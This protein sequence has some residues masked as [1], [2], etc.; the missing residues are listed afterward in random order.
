MLVG[1]RLDDHNTYGSITNIRASLRWQ[2]TD[3]H[4]VRLNFGEA[5]REPTIFELNDSDGLAPIE[6]ETTELTFSYVVPS[7]LVGSLVFWNND[8]TGD[9][10]STSSGSF[11]NATDVTRKRG[12]EWRNTWEHRKWTGYVNAAWTEDRSSEKLLNVAEYKCFTGVT[13]SPDRRFYA[14]LQGRLAWNT[15]TRAVDASGGESI[16]ELD[17]F[18]EVHFHLGIRDL[19]IASGDLEIVLSGRNLFDRRNALPNTRSTDP[20]QFLDERRSFYLK[21]FLQF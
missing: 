3:L 10:I 9:I 4:G 17:D 21:A 14:S 13:W 11:I 15:S 7:R 8:Q 19:G 6:M 18:R 5:F 16:F 20:L 1:G 12:I 2:F